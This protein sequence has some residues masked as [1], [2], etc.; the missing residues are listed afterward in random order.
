MACYSLGMRLGP[1]VFVAVFLAG[2]VV[3]AG[4]LVFRCS[5]GGRIFD[6]ERVR[7]AD[8]RIDKGR[9]VAVGEGLGTEG[10]EEIDC[11]GRTLLPGLIDS[12]THVD[13]DP[14]KGVADLERSLVFGVTTVLDM[15]SLPEF[16]A[17][18]R[19]REAAGAPTGMADMRSSGVMATAPNGHG[20]E[21]GL[22]IPTLSRPEQAESFV[23]ARAADGADY[24]KIVYE[25]SA[26]L[27]TMPSLDQPTLQA[28]VGAAHRH[29]KLAVVHIVSLTDAKD[30]I[31]AGADG[32][33]HLFVTDSPDEAFLA[34]MADRHAFAIP[35]LMVLGASCGLAS[36]TALERDPDL[37]PYLAPAERK[38]L[39]RQERRPFGGPCLER[40]LTTVR[41]LAARG[42][43]ILAG[44]DASLHSST[45]GASIHRELELLAQAGLTSEAA[46]TAATAA[47]AERFGMRDRG[48]IAV[49][50][51]A[52]LLLV[53]GDPTRN[54]RATRRIVGVWKRGVAVDRTAFRNEIA[55]GRRR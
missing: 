1:V 9:I 17:T 28:L 49:G 6:G 26:A 16:V 51:R 23:E 50:L 20:T 5:R 54:L 13:D 14:K 42:V 21:Y 48:R 4:P 39:L 46:L 36:G 31:A 37:R 15:F 10:A 55:A 22:A 2:P 19:A 24:I 40:A 11:R 52:D 41:R 38:N 12:H 32:L 7:M 18:V 8:V 30:A 3:F 25:H 47:P 53:E 34:L 35:T 27:D 33:A 29:G 43:T 45:L 44:T